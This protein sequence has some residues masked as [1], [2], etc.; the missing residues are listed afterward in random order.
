MVSF[1]L[2]L[3][4]AMM[5]T[6]TLAANVTQTAVAWASYLSVVTVTF[7]RSSRPA[8]TVMRMPAVAALLIV[9]DLVRE[10]PV[11]TVKFVLN[12]KLVTM[13]SPMLVVAAMLTVRE[14]EQG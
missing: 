2:N 11:A 7:V 6:P 3:R 9:A 5:A 14:R 13:V 12:S 4:L 10:P 8:M 1:V